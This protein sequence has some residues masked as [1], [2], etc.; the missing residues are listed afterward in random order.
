MT[1]QIRSLKIP[2][3]RLR[4]LIKD[5]TIAQIARRFGVSANKITYTMKAYGIE[6]PRSAKNASINNDRDKTSP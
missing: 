5:N 2:E 4:D 6:T 1:A 3:K